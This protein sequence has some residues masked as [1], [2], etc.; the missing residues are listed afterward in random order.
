MRQKSVVKGDLIF[1]NSKKYF[2]YIA[3][4]GMVNEPVYKDN[5]LMVDKEDL[6]AEFESIFKYASNDTTGLHPIKLIEVPK[7]NYLYMLENEN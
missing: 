4:R 5:I 2:K 1:F 6:L 3:L 7:E